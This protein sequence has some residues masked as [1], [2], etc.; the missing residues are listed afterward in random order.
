MKAG[1][2]GVAAVCLVLASC[3]QSGGSGETQVTSVD[4]T[5]AT[6]YAPASSPRVLTATGATTTVIFMHGKTGTP[7]ASHLNTFLADLNNQ[8]Y[9]VIAPFMPWS[10]TEWTGTLCEGMAYISELAD[11]EIVLNKN[12]IVAGHSM[13]GVHALIYGADP[14]A[15]PVS[16]IV[17]I[18]PGHMVH[19]SMRMQSV[20]AA[21]VAR[22]KDLENGGNDA[23]ATFVTLNNG[24]ETPISATPSAYLSFH[25]P[26]RFPDIS[27]LLPG[28]ATPVLW[29]AGSSDDLTSI[30]GMQSTAATI[31]STGSDYQ[32]L[33]GDHLGVVANASQ[34]V[35]TW[36]G[37][38]N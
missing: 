9:D 11:Q 28:I 1:Y 24:A 38:L 4:C 35:I 22:A 37:G 32:L 8:G 5:G 20:T 13:G 30:Y 14:A 31:T 7:Y 18:A 23:L 33:S 25:D 26:D 10:G 12:V 15:T 19:E 2:A 16:A 3:A 29:L 36:Y 6:P 34:P 17:A 27:A 21:D